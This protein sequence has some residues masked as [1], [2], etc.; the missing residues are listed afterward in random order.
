M[1]TRDPQTQDERI[2]QQEDALRTAIMLGDDE[3]TIEQ[4]RDGLLYLREQK[5]K[6][7][8]EDQEP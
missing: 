2:K 7:R 6:E 8:Q 1:A 3:E 5:A 4:L